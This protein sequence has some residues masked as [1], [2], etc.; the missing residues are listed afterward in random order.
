MRSVLCRACGPVGQAEV[1][2][3]K[4]KGEERELV[5]RERGEDGG[6]GEGKARE[7]QKGN[8]GIKQDWE[9]GGTCV[10]RLDGN[11][12]NQSDGDR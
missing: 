4:N 7:M 11:Q 3:G 5:G 12:E 6:G 8:E 9:G 2:R 1:A 10:W